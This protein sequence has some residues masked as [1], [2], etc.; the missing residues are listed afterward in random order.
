MADLEDPHSPP[1]PRVLT[2]DQ[3]IGELVAGL[4]A[5]LPAIV[6]QLADLLG[7]SKPRLSGQKRRRFMADLHRR[8]KRLWPK[9][10]E[11]DALKTAPESLQTAETVKAALRGILIEMLAPPRIRKSADADRLEWLIALAATATNPPRTAW[12]RQAPYLEAR[13]HLWHVLISVYG[14]L[15]L[16]AIQAV[17][18]SWIA[19]GPDGEYKRYIHSLRLLVVAAARFRARP[20]QRISDRAAV[21]LHNEYL[22]SAS[23]FEQQLRLLTCLV[24]RAEGAAKPWSYWRQQSLKNLMEMASG[25]DELGKLVPFVDR[26]V[27][28]A[29]THG[30]PLVERS[31]RRCVFHDRDVCVMWS[32][33]DYFCNTRAL[34]LAVLACAH[35]DSFRQLI[36]VQ[37]LARALSARSEQ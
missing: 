36:E 17:F 28:N 4:E 19:D 3:A 24:R 30:P 34:T 13:T 5:N 32:W 29:L 10:E 23:L 6:T 12:A 9:F 22:R 27:R 31:A 35:F 15:P 20:T 14:R 8:L 1:G 18:D 16:A 33:E 21:D 26:H 37:I 11:L 7:K 2:P 25:H